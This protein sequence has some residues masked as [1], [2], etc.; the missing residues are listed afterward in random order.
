HVD[1]AHA[2]PDPSRSGHAEGEE[3]RAVSGAETLA[4]ADPRTVHRAPR[5]ARIGVLSAA[6]GL[7]SCALVTWLFAQP[8]E[9]LSLPGVFLLLAVFLVPVFVF[10]GLAIAL[11]LDGWSRRRARK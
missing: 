1:P 7:I 10:A 3:G 8:T 6:V 9:F 4:L 11:L 2:D 5:F